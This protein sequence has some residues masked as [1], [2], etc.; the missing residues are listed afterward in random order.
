MKSTTLTFQV[1]VT[2]ESDEPLDEDNCEVLRAEM[3]STLQ[4]ANACGHLDPPGLAIQSFALEVKFTGEADA[5][6]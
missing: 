2:Y 3:D 4:N 6:L 5:T 1:S